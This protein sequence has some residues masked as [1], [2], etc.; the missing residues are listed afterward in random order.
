VTNY[1]GLPQF[2]DVVFERPPLMLTLFQIQFPTVLGVENPQYVAPFQEAIRERYPNLLPTNQVEMQIAM[3]AGE[4]QI[5]RG[6]MF[7]QW[8]FS[9][10]DDNWVVV[11]G[12]NFVTLETRSYEHFDAFVD[13]IQF[14]I[15]ALIAHIRPTVGLRIG[16]RYINEIRSP[17]E[18]VLSF[19]RPQLLGPLAV[20]S[21]AAHLI[22]GVQELRLAFEQGN[23]LNIR[24]GYVPQG[25]TV[26]PRT[27]DERFDEPF[28]LLDF[29]AFYEFS[30]LEP[31]AM[32]SDMICN[33][34]NDYHSLIYQLFR[35]SVTETYVAGLGV[36]HHEVH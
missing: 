8:R 23:G 11:L 30:P 25:T 7:R 26:Q 12:H 2:P 10:M 36:R 19:I 14:I 32:Q 17:D 35:W 20:D 21:V 16:L 27:D 3:A 29:D 24:H 34:V 13:Q 1:L 22:Q 5:R 18:D 15:D 33:Y 4:A 9:D 28:Y 6:E 31:L